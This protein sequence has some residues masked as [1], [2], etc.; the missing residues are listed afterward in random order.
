MSAA[1]LASAPTA[2]PAAFRLPAG[3]CDCHF[4][5]FDAARYPYAPQRHY[6]PPDATLS[7]YLAL[8]ER[9]GIERSVLIHPTVFG[10][11]HQSFEDILRQHG[12]HMRGIAVVAPTTPEA[13]IE[14]WHRLGARGTRITTMFSAPPDMQTVEGIVAKV[15]PFGWHVQLLVDVVQQPDLVAQVQAM[16]VTVV[17]DHMGH[18]AAAAIG[19]SAGFANL[20]AQLAE[21]T[22]WVKLSAPYR[23]SP[24]CHADADVRRLAER[25]VRTNPQRLL[26]GTDWPHPS[27][28]HAVPDDEQLVS[29]VPDWLPDD[30]VRE[31]VLVHNPTHL[32]WQ[33]PSQG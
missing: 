29:L 25:Y 19:Q 32:Y 4:H 31:T 6:T 30:R 22:A 20:L 18:H 21:G 7:S 2:R 16:G 26:W 17:V 1:H 14:R 12:G 3:A 23:V 11:D 24:Q 10:A 5:V 28:P 8:C 9:F 15:R 13:D 33:E 27:S